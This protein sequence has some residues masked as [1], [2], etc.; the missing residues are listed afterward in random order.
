ME[1]NVMTTEQRQEIVKNAIEAGTVFTRGLNFPVGKYEFRLL[2]DDAFSTR[3]ITT[4]SGNEMTLFL[5]KGEIK[6]AEAIDTNGKKIAKGTIVDK[7]HRSIAVDIPD[8][9]A[10]M[11]LDVLYNFEV[12]EYEAT[13]TKDD[14][15]TETVLRKTTQNWCAV[16]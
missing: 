16:S 12:V 13:R 3:E 9:W 6:A 14:G 2:S 15:T 4:R 10:D 11:Q 5:T 8:L 7:G 1:K